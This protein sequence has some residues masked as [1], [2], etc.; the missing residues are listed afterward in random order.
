[1]WIIL[2]GKGNVYDSQI[3]NIEDCGMT[4]PVR[5]VEVEVEGER[6]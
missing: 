5:I 1:V 2:T 6:V 3:L 4:D